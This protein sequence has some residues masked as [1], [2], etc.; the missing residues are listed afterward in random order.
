VISPL[1]EKGYAL[2]VSKGERTYHG[3]VQGK[4][5]VWELEESHGARK[6]GHDK[7]VPQLSLTLVVEIVHTILLKVAL[8]G[9]NKTNHGF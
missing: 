3:A 6:L 1:A 8:W 5:K 9:K 2:I 7:A 4:G